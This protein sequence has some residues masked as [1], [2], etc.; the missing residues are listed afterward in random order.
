MVDD[1]HADSAP[2]AEFQASL[3]HN[4]RKDLVSFE[5]SGVVRIG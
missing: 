3:A 1:D 2:V 5:L 4:A